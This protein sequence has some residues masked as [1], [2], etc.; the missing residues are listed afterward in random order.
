MT[1]YLLAIQKESPHQGMNDEIDNI[2]L[3][4]SLKE[5]EKQLGWGAGEKWTTQDFA[6]LSTKIFE[7]TGV[8]LS[9]TTLKRLWGRVNY[10]SKPTAGTL[11]ALVQF[12]G[13][14]NWQSYLQKYKN[15]ACKPLHR[16]APLPGFR[17]TG[18]EKENLFLRPTPSFFRENLRDTAPRRWS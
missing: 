10:G 8:A 7:K 9:V 5:V 13:Y 1:S 2:T 12:I 14:E 11:N 18:M 4:H 3:L 6:D 16:R 15:L 17:H